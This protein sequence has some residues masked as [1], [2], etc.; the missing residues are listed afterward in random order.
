MFRSQDRRR[1]GHREARD[2]KLSRYAAEQQENDNLSDDD[3]A[4]PEMQPEAEMEVEQEDPLL[5]AIDDLQGRVAVALDDVRVHTG[6]RS[7]SGQTV[8]E[9][10]GE[11]LRPVLEVAAHTSPSVARTYYRGI[12]AEGV[13]ASC[14]D[15]YQHVVS[16]LVLPSLLEMAQADTMPARRGAALEFFRQ[17]WKECHKPGS[18]LDP[19]SGVNAG[20]YG[21]GQTDRH[22]QQQ[23]QPRPQWRRRQATRM[24]REGEVLRYWVQASIA[25]TVPGVF[26]NEAAEAAIAA[27][28]VI[29]ASASIRPSFKHIAQRI[30]DTDDRG[31]NRVFAPVLKMIEGVLKRLFISQETQ[32]AEGD[33]LR[34]SCIKFLEIVCLCCSAKPQDP[35]QR[36]R[37]TTPDDFSLEDLP[38]GHPII[39]R[40]SL[41][42]ISEYAFSALRGLAFL[43]GQV[44]IDVNLLSDLL[45]GGDNTPAA[46]VVSILKPAALAYLE[47]ESTLPKPDSEK[48][49]EISI[50]RSSLEFDF[51]LSPKSYALNINAVAAIATNRPVFFNEGATCLARR[52]ADPPI[53]VEGGP[54]PKHAVL[55]IQAQVKA[56]CLTLLRNALS[57]QTQSFQILH[58]CLSEKCDMEVQ[59]DKA[60]KMAEQ[61]NALKT[62]GRAARNRANI[63]YE[64]DTSADSSRTTKRQRETD[65]DLDRIRAARA[66]RGL[67]NGIQLPT[68]MVDAIELVLANLKH[69]PSKRQ[70]GAAAASN[71]RKAPVTL[72]FVIDAIMTN[73]ASLTQEEGRWY[74][75]D[76]GSAWTSENGNYEISSNLLSVLG[77]NVAKENKSKQELQAIKDQKAMF[78]SQCKTASSEAVGR[79]ILKGMGSR[80]ANVTEFA[81]TIAARLAWT[82][83]N[84]PAP[85]QLTDAHGVALDAIGSSK[86]RLE[87]D[88]QNTPLDKLA[89]SFPLVTSCL[90]LEATSSVNFG[91][92]SKTAPSLSNAVLNEAYAQDFE[93]SEDK[94]DKTAWKYNAG[95]DIYAGCVLHA[96]ERANDKATDNDRKRVATSLASNLQKEFGILP[97]LTSSAMKL[98]S[99][100]CDIDEIVK[101]VAEAA[102]K[103]SQ[104][105]IATSAA[106]H[107]A[108]Q[109]AEK[110][111]TAAL[112]V[113]RDAAFQ[114]TNPKTRKSAVRTAVALAAGHFH[115]SASCEDK[116]LK[117]VMNVL[118]ARSETLADDVVEACIAELKVASDEAV[119]KYDEVKNANKEAAVKAAGNESAPK[120]PFAPESDTEKAAMDKARKPA[121]LVMALCIRRPEMIK[122][123]FELSSVP[124]A[125]VLSK[126]VRQQ[127]P[128]LAR[129]VGTQFGQAEIALRVADMATQAEIPFLLA[130]LDN[131]A[132]LGEKGVPSQEFID[133]CFKIQENKSQ[134]AKKDP[135]FLIP[136]VTGMLR[137]DLVARL[138]EFVDTEDSIFIA[139]LSKMSERLGR[140]ALLFRDEPDPETPTLKGLTACEQLVYLHKL[141]FQASN[142][143]QKRYL[144]VIRLCLDNEEMFNDSLIVSALDH[145]SGSFLSGE[146]KLPLA[147]MRTII[148][149]CSKHESLH[150]WICHTLLPR[151]VEG[152]IYEDRRQWEGWMRCAKIL[153]NSSGNGASSAEA[154]NKLPPEQLA[155][156]RERYGGSS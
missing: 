120:G 6:V 30:R 98:V 37:D 121:L 74:S 55:G 77:T 15:V 57:V 76:G 71:K 86:K 112:L 79:I 125:D 18:W 106:L 146:E 119:S 110:R 154:V 10:L 69:L 138:P 134:G 80:S 81:N 43:G 155:L 56:T 13:E 1:E 152:R 83:G 124:K 102:R 53:Y 88:N 33:A 78:E 132:P 48:S 34:S 36:R 145:M 21:S 62:A 49:V 58:K 4:A 68:S 45:M 156:Y 41:G 90:A 137:D 82:L 8:Q 3:N 127:M 117:L 25:C 147:F 149:V 47:I 50:D 16:D 59:A 100:M 103:Q 115:A 99:A 141:D 91:L 27:R 32:S 54:M 40:E 89:T 2:D 148:M 51:M 123:L 73:G 19:S 31:A 150:S 101:K 75:R 17:L 95:L 5:L 122:T 129:A 105:S 9:E 26:T 61:T 136:V 128:K 52:A 151:L 97:S 126:A 130:F 93:H 153:E 133:A 63:Y 46:Q 72:D 96:S 44:R 139:A 28:G 135:R 22:L 143:P 14:E 111:A 84:V 108:K 7:G 144:D 116:A 11:L 85:S 29:A 35:S 20:P 140:Q 23:N 94:A 66:S 39:T 104:Q 114:R 113:L 64:W 118:F 24:A 42:S 67:G 38:E 87:V 142:L 92:D 131:L 107:A 60:L 12:G 65:D 109:A 70:A